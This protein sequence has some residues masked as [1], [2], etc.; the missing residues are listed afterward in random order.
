MLVNPL[1]RQVLNANP[2]GDNQYVNPD[3]PAKDPIR[4][5]FYGEG[6]GPKITGEEFDADNDP[7]FSKSLSKFPVVAD[8]VYR[9]S[10]IT[11]KAIKSLLKSGKVTVP[12]FKSGSKSKEFA[13]GWAIDHDQ[14]KTHPVVYTL[15]DS[16]A[17]DISDI[18]PFQ[19]EA[20]IPKSN[21]R[22]MGMS[23]LGDHIS[24]ILRRIKDEQ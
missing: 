10:R 14:P 8:P 13:R 16:G 23:G 21:Y 20:I 4:R 5:W 3:G 12:R 6:M 9:G 22:V 2:K 7:E 17:S 18:N 19:Q 11:R 24:V 15:E 1:T